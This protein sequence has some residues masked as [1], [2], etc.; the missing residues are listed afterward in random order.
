MV[1]VL[2]VTPRL[3]TLW[4]FL[5]SVETLSYLLVIFLCSFMYFMIWL[6]MDE[7]HFISQCKMQQ[8]LLFLWFLIPRSGNDQPWTALGASYYFEISMKSIGKIINAYSVGLGTFV[9]FIMC[10]GREQEPCE[11]SWTHKKL[12]LIQNSSKQSSLLTKWMA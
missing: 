8:L 1:M 2:L 4:V 9:E 5:R 12:P 7:K 10:Q 3:V 6:D 11:G